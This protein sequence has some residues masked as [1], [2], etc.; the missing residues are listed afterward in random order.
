MFVQDRYFFWNEKEKAIYS[1]LYTLETMHKDSE[2]KDYCAGVMF[3]NIGSMLMI[4]CIQD[5]SNTYS[6]CTEI[7]YHMFLN[8]TGSESSSLMWSQL[9]G[10][11]KAATPL[12]HAHIHTTISLDLQLPTNYASNVISKIPEHPKNDINL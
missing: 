6:F 2:Q 4:P 5:W 8:L 12:H 7:T 10:F 1:K 11:L 9:N 3:P